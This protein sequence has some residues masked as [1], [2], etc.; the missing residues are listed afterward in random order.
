MTKIILF[1]FKNYKTEYKFDD[2]ELVFNRIK[3]KLKSLNIN[4]F[5]DSTSFT[6][7]DSCNYYKF[8]VWVE[9]NLLKDNDF[10]KSLKLDLMSIILKKL[11][12]PSEHDIT[13]YEK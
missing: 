9:N 7:R 4:L 13:F 1:S 5:G 12:A 6:R 11:E 8:D 10:Y 3:D 2:V